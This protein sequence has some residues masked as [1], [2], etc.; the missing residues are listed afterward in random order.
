[1]GKPSFLNSSH[2]KK[3]S[4]YKN[5][6]ADRENGIHLVPSVNI[7]AIDCHG[8]SLKDFLVRSGF[9]FTIKTRPFYPSAKNNSTARYTPELGS[10]CV[11]TTHIRTL[12][13][14]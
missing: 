6:N 1:M 7:I 14:S 3:R 9:Q 11:V 10:E 4:Y 8:V 5:L 2:G 13:L 12:A